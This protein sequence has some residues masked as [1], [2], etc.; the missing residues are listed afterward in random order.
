M[1][2]SLFAILLGASLLAGCAPS[3]SESDYLARRARL[4]RQNQGIRELIAEQEKGS[5]VPSDRF[6]IGIHESILGELFRSQLPLERPLGKRFVVR[7][8]SATVSL[9]DKFGL[10]TIEG[11]VHRPK[12]PDR[13]TAVRIFGGLD[14]VAIDPATGMLHMRIAIDQ[15]DILQAGILES[16]LGAGGRKFLAQVGRPMIQEAIPRF[17]IPVVLGRSIRVPPVQAAGLQLDSLQVPL[18]LSVQRVIAAAGRLWVTIHAD[19]GTV[20]GAEQGLGVAVKKKPK[21]KG[22]S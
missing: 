7:L 13:K 9:R 1:L 4:E 22:T 20:T 10:I 8:E 2:R 6:L 11:S 12:T 14:S 16:V 17:E 5:L 15:I 19:I 3:E 21:K 18:Q